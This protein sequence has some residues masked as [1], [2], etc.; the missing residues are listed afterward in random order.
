MHAGRHDDAICA[1]SDLLSLNPTS[2]QGLLIKRSRAYV[3]KGVWENGLKDANKVCPFP[4][5]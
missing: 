4:V 3:A 5:S 1:Y 2:P